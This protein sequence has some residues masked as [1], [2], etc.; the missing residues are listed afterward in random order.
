M[1]GGYIARD[2]GIL[3]GFS[4]IDFYLQIYIIIDTIGYMIF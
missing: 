1:N 4:S 3:L 2:G